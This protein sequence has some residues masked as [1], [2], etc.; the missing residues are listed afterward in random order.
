MKNNILTICL[1]CASVYL[2]EGQPG[3]EEVATSTDKVDV[4]VSGEEGYHTYRIPAMLT[5][6]EGTLLAFAEGR[7]E[8]GGDAGNIDMLIKRSEDGGR[9]WSGQLV[10]WDEGPNTCGNPCPVLDKETGTV[11]LLMTHNLGADDERD[12]IHKKAASTRTVWVTKSEDD[13]KS[14][15]EP[16]EITG[17]VKD[18]SWGW[19]ATGPGVGIQIEHGPYKGRLVIPCDHSYDDPEGDVREGPYQYGSHVI[20][21]DDHGKT[22]ELGGTITPKVNECQVVEVADGNGTLLMNMRSYFGRSRRTQAISY[23][24]GATWTAPED[25]PGLVEPVCQAG[26]LRYS[27]PDKGQKSVLLFLNP[28]STGKRHHM[29]IRASY[30]EG[31]TWPVI[32]TLW[33]GPAAYSSL[34]VLSDG[35]IGC[36]YEAGSARPYEKIVYE[37]LDPDRLF[38]K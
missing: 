27:W 15:S 8:A 11:W 17:D 4:F 22:W 16:V 12:I 19:Y 18:P 6:N 10:V 30:D 13:G 31:K 7:K 35:D 1:I 38:K 37:R 34:S 3:N 24:G 29:T 26:F 33:P 28:A 2:T 21:S 25:V 5:T 9:T 36:L 23:D 14:W 20:Y 32:K